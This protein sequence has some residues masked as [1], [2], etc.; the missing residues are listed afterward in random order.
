VRPA[1]EVGPLKALVWDVDGTL[2]ETE[3]DGHRVAFNAAFEAEGLPWRW[4]ERRY[5]DLLHVAGGYERLLHD[6][7]SQPQAPADAAERERL[8][9][10]LHRLKN[11]RYTRIV[12]SGAIPLR[13]GV[14]ELMDDCSAAGIAMGIA[15][16]TTRSNVDALLAV[17]LGP[18]WQQRFACVLC[19][20]DAPLKKPDPQIYLL[21]LERLGCRADEML[22]IEDSSPGLRAGLAAGIGVVLVRSVYFADI[23]AA[24]ALAAGPSLARSEGWDPAAGGGRIDLAQLLAWRGRRL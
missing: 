20:D 13:A 3:R 5:G 9:R 12:E 19:A 4:D 1:P 18:Q 16:T 17:H 8:A 10:H 7:A 14:R 24:G 21:A 2:A 6:L 11:E 23:P 22:A 15:T